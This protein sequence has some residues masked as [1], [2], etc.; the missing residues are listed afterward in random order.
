MNK[1]TEVNGNVLL[2]K[3][4]D[5]IAAQI[6][7]VP[8]MVLGEAAAVSTIIFLPYGARFKVKETPDE[9][10]VMAQRS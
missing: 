5:I 8:S 4:E 9:I 7:S 3:A 10:F 2:V 6:E 1:L